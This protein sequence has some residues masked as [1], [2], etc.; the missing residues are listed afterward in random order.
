M[1]C[2]CKGVGYGCVCTKDGECPDIPYA[3]RPKCSDEAIY[4]AQVAGRDSDL[5]IFINQGGSMTDANFAKFLNTK[6]PLTSWDISQKQKN[7]LTAIALGVE[8]EAYCLG[9]GAV[10]IAELPKLVQ[11]IMKWAKLIMG[12]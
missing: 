3:T 6:Y 9:A 5:S 4:L 7:T 1:P 10:R 2:W 11:D 12:L 8:V